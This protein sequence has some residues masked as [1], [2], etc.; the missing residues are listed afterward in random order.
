L[1]GIAPDHVDVDNPYLERKGL[2]QA[3]AVKA[4]QILM[5]LSTQLQQ[6]E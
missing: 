4:E 6:Q 3:F 5:H 1:F 2:A